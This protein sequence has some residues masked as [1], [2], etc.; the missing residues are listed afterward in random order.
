MDDIF[1]LDDYDLED[2]ELVVEVT[3]N[4]EDSITCDV[5]YCNKDNSDKYCLAKCEF[6]NNCYANH[7]NC[8]KNKVEELLNTLSKTESHI[9]RL[10]YGYYGKEKDINDIA[11]ELNL[12]PARIKQFLTKALRKLRH[13]SRSKIIKNFEFEFFSTPS[14]SFYRN[15]INAMCGTYHSSYELGVDFCIVDEEKNFHKTPKQ[16][17]GEISKSISEFEELK[18]YLACL[19]KLNITSMNHLLHIPSKK[20]LSNCFQ[21]DADYYKFVN[22]INEM[23]YHFKDQCFINIIK[24]EKT[25]E[26][27][28]VV[29][30]E[31]ELSKPIIELPLGLSLELIDKNCSTIFD[32]TNILAEKGFKGIYEFGLSYK[33]AEVIICNYLLSKN[34]LKKTGLNKMII[35]NMADLK[36]YINSLIDW[37]MV[38]NKSID[39]LIKD[40]KNNNAYWFKA[41]SVIEEKYPEFIKTLDAEIFSSI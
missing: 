41:I 3:A 17:C 30:N 21:S 4:V 23:G 28:S 15:L 19:K 9:L 25:N 32:L 35:F 40:L 1:D 6:Y 18:P 20:I 26:L 10:K 37:M 33:H 11:G 7:D 29:L 5:T 31:T 14:T 36:K 38:L 2:D 12:S 39:L 16:I 34:L 13:P 24:E 27:F 22:E 8:A